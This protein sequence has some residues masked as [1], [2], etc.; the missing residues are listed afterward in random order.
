MAR[1]KDP[2]KQ[3][4]DQLTFNQMV[5]SCTSAPT[6]QADL[7]GRR[8]APRRQG[9]RGRP[10][11]GAPRSSLEWKIAPPSARVACTAHVYHVQQSM[12]PRECRIPHLTS[13]GVAK[14]PAKTGG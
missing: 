5:G 11:G 13:G 7:S 10:G 3:I 14:N 9:L 4:D 1:E 6:G 2:N 8:R 12:E